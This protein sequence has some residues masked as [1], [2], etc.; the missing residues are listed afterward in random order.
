MRWTD[1]T[2][3]NLFLALAAVLLAVGL[4]VDIGFI[5][6]QLR[7]LRQLSL[8]RDQLLIQIGQGM[9][10]S[11][12]SQTLT[13]LLNVSELSLLLPAETDPDPLTYLGELLNESR[14]TRLE[15]THAGRTVTDQLLRTQFMLRVT[16]SYDR[17]LNFV[18]AIERGPR[19]AVVDAFSIEAIKESQMLE[20]RLQVSIYEPVTRRGRGA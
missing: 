6:P 18:R 9:D 5:Q 1:S 13:R 3:M 7:Q 15:L 11:R 20:S 2:R 14:L 17:T 8:Q 12:N 16:G 19:L 4:T 10:R